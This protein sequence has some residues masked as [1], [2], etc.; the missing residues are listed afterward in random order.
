MTE[1]APPPPVPGGL[2]HP[3]I[4]A[5]PGSFYI[6]AW[7]GLLRRFRKA[8]AVPGEAGPLHRASRHGAAGG[9]PLRQGAGEEHRCGVSLSSEAS[10]DT[11]TTQP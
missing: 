11:R 3:S 1:P 8:V 5:F 6:K 9:H 10:H 7:A 2:D 4:T